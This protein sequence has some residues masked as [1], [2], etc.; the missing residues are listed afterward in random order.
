[1]LLVCSTKIEGERSCT[2]SLAT[3]AR[4]FWFSNLKARLSFSNRRIALMPVSSTVLSKVVDGAVVLFGTMT[5]SFRGEI[6]LASARAC[7]EP[8]LSESGIRPAGIMSCSDSITER[9]L[10]DGDVTFC[11]RG[12]VGDRGESVP[13][14]SGVL[15]CTVGAGTRGVPLVRVPPAE[16]V[17]E[18]CEVALVPR[19]I[20]AR[21]AR[22]FAWF[23]R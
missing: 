2:S 4:S 20:V 12:D 15:N 5:I 1:M 22:C 7:A 16:E 8:L 19:E 10:P 17:N 13:D 14:G 23:I 3:R 18:G 6:K 21:L 9:R 11:C